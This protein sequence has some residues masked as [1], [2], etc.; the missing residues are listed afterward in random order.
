MACII[1][2]SVVLVEPDPVITIT[3]PESEEVIYTDFYVVATVEPVT[4]VVTS[5]S[6]TSYV[7]GVEQETVAM[8]LITPPATWRATMTFPAGGGAGAIDVGFIID[9]SIYSDSIPVSFVAA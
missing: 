6:A 7:G 1:N 2:A 5:A 8:A 3:D 4:A 9:G